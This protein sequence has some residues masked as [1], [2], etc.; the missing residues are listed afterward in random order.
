M[1]QTLYHD[2]VVNLEPQT[3]DHIWVVNPVN[4]NPKIQTLN[5]IWVVN[6][7]ALKP[8]P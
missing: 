4:L 6:P 1:T 7:E 3:L 5:H 2:G 8:K